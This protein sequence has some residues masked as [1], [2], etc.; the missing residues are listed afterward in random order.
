[1]QSSVLPQNWQKT[2]EHSNPAPTQAV[3]DRLVP[4]TLACE[5]TLRVTPEA[6]REQEGELATTFLEFE[7]LHRKSRCEMLIGGDEIGIDV[8]TLNTC[9]LTF[10]LVSASP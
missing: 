7:Y 10:A 6:G 3:D 4:G 9:L 8:I 1:M 5:Q 2:C